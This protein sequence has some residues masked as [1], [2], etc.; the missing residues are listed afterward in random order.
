[1][2]GVV[3]ESFIFWTL[4]QD[5]NRIEA[6]INL[7]NVFSI[8]CYSIQSSQSLF[9]SVQNGAVIH[10]SVYYAI[11]CICRKDCQLIASYMKLLQLG[12]SI[13]SQQIEN[14]CIK[15]TYTYYICIQ[16]KEWK[17]K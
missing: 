5:Y 3:R 9:F 6:S 8:V 10:S 16:L 1:M 15:S 4:Q 12:F 17:T 2:N 13:G 11:K 14:D 7:I